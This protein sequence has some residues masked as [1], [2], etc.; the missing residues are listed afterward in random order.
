MTGDELKKK[1]TALELT[2]AQLAGLLDVKPNTVTRW[3]NGV[4]VVPRTV[5]LA[6]DTI[7]REHGKKKSGKK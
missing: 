4:L 7:E 2:Q 1:R 3:E 5:E 6:M